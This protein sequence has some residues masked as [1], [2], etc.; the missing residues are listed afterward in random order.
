[1]NNNNNNNNANIF[2]FGALFEDELNNI[3]NFLN[4]KKEKNIYENNLYFN[5]I[6]DHIKLFISK[7]NYTSVTIYLIAN[8][9]DNNELIFH[10]N[11]DK[12]KSI[13]HVI[14]I[15]NQQCINKNDEYV[16]IK[17]KTIYNNYKSKGKDENIDILDNFINLYTGD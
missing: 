1:M 13:E 3:K 5:S 2:I 17:K 6:I 10:C 14:N 11:N 9:T 7:E 8:I 15:L 4:S 12:K 16:L